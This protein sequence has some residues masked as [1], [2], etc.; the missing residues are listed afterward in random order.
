MMHWVLW[1]SLMQHYG[2][3]IN[4]ETDLMGDLSLLDHAIYFDSKKYSSLP[5]LPIE[6]NSLQ[7]ACLIEIN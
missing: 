1:S 7:K 2:T 3:I 4:D 6:T 5:K